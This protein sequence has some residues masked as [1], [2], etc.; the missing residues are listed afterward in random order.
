[1]QPASRQRARLNG[2]KAASTSG[3]LTDKAYAKQLCG[4][5]DEKRMTYD[6]LSDDRCRDGC[7]RRVHVS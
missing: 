4:M 7:E 5:L 3:L 2:I 1:M 6:L